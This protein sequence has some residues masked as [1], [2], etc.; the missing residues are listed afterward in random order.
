MTSSK[1][2]FK[3]HSTSQAKTDRDRIVLSRQAE[4]HLRYYRC[5]EAARHHQNFASLCQLSAYARCMFDLKW[6]SRLTQTIPHSDRSIL[7][8][9]RLS[10]TIVYYLHILTCLTSRLEPPSEY[11]LVTDP[12]SHVHCGSRSFSTFTVTSSSSP[13]DERKPISIILKVIEY[14]LTYMCIFSKIL[15]RFYFYHRQFLLM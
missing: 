3:M 4:S 9:N 12:V 5:L 2:C 1:L 15:I 14:W 6:H 8:S 13:S 11:S 10:I 7:L